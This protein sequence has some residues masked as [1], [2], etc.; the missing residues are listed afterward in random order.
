MKK[1]LSLMVS[2][3]FF[4]ITTIGQK[5]SDVLENGIKVKSGNEVFIRFDGTNILYQTGQIPNLHFKQIEDSSMLLP[6]D[7][8]I[9]FYIRPLNPLNYS[10]KAENKIILD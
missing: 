1:F 9:I 6:V 7:K 4:Y 10:F 5:A 2:I 8:S 3:L